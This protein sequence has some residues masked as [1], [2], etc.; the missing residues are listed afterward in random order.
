MVLSFFILR[1]IKLKMPPMSACIKNEDRKQKN[2]IPSMADTLGIFYFA[3]QGGQFFPRFRG[4]CDSFEKPNRT[5]KE[6]YLRKSD[7]YDDDILSV[8]YVLILTRRK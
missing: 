5:K 7:E 4:A 3:K 8:H 2:T 1:Y 6:I